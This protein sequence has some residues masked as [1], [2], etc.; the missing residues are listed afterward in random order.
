M[1]PY[2]VVY[3]IT[4]RVNGKVYV[5]QTTHTLSRRFGEHRRYRTCPAIGAAIQKY[6]AENFSIEPIYYALDRYEL[7]D[8]EQFLIKKFN[9]MYPNGYNLTTGGEHFRM[10][11]E[12]AAKI[13]VAMKGKRHGAGPR[14]EEAR[15][16]MS[17]VRLGKKRY[18]RCASGNAAYVKQPLARRITCRDAMTGIEVSYPSMGMAKADGYKPAG[19]AACC[20]GKYS[21]H[22]GKQW[23]WA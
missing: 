5:G 14:S 6:G 16:V 1:K 21:Q 15:R 9:S 20:N 18:G 11:K 7:N 19:I 13:S 22:H 8:K 2:G 12:S 17:Q 10:S 4:N 3:K 23:R